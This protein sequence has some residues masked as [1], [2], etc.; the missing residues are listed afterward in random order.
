[1]GPKIYGVCGTRDPEEIS[2]KLKEI[3]DESGCKT[4]AAKKMG[5]SKFTLYQWYKKYNVDVPTEYPKTRPDTRGKRGYTVDL[6]AIKSRLGYDSLKSMLTYCDNQYTYIEAA[7]VLGISTS[8][9]K[10]LRKDYGFIQG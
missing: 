4:R 1:M 9:Y 10:K 2:K 7:D 3:Y 6:N 5:I 8:T